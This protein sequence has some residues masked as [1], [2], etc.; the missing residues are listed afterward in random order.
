MATTQSVPQIY[1]AREHVHVLV[2]NIEAR[3]IQE[4]ECGELGDLLQ[5]Q[6]FPWYDG[7]GARRALAR[8]TDGQTAGYLAEAECAADLSRLQRVL[9]PWEQ[10]VLR[11]V[12]VDTADAVEEVAQTLAFGLTEFAVAG[13]LAAGLWERGL[14]PIVVLV[15]G[16]ARTE[17]R[18]HPLPTSKRI[19]HDAILSVCGRRRGLVAS[20]TRSVH[21][22]P[23][24]EERRVRQAQVAAV[25]AAAMACSRPGIS[26]REVFAAMR[27]AYARQGHPQAWTQHHQGGLSGYASRTK[28][29]TD[30]T[31]LML[32]AGMVLAYNPS[33]PGA[34]SEDT[35]LLG[36]DGV[37]VVS[38]SRRNWPLLAVDVEGR[39]WNRPM[40][41]AR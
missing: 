16:D 31:D 27:E 18:R 41:W 6:D 17:R 1:V 21:R 23:V 15:S 5:F 28:L 35:C 34:K 24:P 30:E 19:D 8:T 13:R 14:E 4:E 37:S 10:E 33:L 29:A 12:A 26:L 32:E 20:V 3:R 11:S 25:D 36:P 22:G 40:V 38:Q 7:D 39:V 2:N 9:D